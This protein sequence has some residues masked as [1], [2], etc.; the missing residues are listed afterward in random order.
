MNESYAHSLDFSFFSDPRNQLEKIILHLES[1]NLQEHG[2]IEEYIRTQG[3]E[4]LRLLLQGFLDKQADDEKIES[5]VSDADG[6][7][8]N[9]VR[10]NTSRK[11]ISLFG[12]VTVKRLAYSQRNK[13][14]VFPM[15]ARLNL[16]SDQ[17]S[18]GVRKRITSDVVDRSYDSAV[19]RHCETTAGAIGKR[20]AI[21]LSADTSQDFVTFYEQR[22]V[23]NENT[24]DLLVLTADGKGIVMLPDGLRE[25]TRKNAEK[26][27]QKLQTRLSSGEKKDRKRMAQVAAVYT[28]RPN[29]R[30][31]ESV[32]NL[33][34]ESNV[35]QFRPPSRNKRVW[36]SVE[37][38]SG[39]VIEEAFEEA[40]RRDPKQQRHWVILI[41]GHPHQLGLIKRVM[42]EKRL[43][44]TIVMDFIHVLEYLWKAVWCLF[45]KGDSKAEKW[46]EERAL[47]ILKG[48]SG[49]VARGIKQSASKRGLK[50]REAIDKC[51]R[52]L[53]KY[54]PY[55]RY[56]KALSGGYPIASGVIEGACRHLI[57]DRLDV[58]GARW[59]LQGAEAILKLRSLNSSGDWED[60]WSFH[61]KCSEQRN[62]ADLVIKG[63]S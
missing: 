45:E 39:Q 23:E 46:V 38:E 58:T 62:Y 19:K 44:A 5:F 37:R 26:S 17:Y 48:Q 42:K 52:Y 24:D 61:R 36:A 15:D 60:Y 41:D 55:M 21:A 35:R 3:N 34:K 8:L 28:T 25:I 40:L 33:D 57:N 32:I 56:D 2:I 16:Y 49:R 7:H 13:A 47:K 1:A 12:S 30:S 20:Q 63:A 27:K 18:D 10:K 54:E 9:H 14:S 22:K 4:L 11:L 51:A 29:P 53:Q 6:S 59:S 43:K 50:K 31:A